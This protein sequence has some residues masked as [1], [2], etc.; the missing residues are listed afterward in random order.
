M[1]NNVI[2][3]NTN[4][5]AVIAKWEDQL[6]EEVKSIIQS[7]RNLSGANEK[8]AKSAKSMN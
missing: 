4:R 2:L 5:L 3:K 1:S 6:V 8:G 7:G